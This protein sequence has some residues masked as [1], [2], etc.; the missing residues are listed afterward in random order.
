MDL[1]IMETVRRCHDRLA[2][3]RLARQRFKRFTYGRQWDDTM[4]TPDGSRVT[5]G[6]Y[7]GLNGRV[8][9][10]NNMIH[11]VVKTIIGH[12]RTSVAAEHPAPKAAAFNRLDELDARM[13]E[14][15]L[16]SG[17]AVQRVV[18]EHRPAGTGLWVDNVNPDDFFCSEI[19]DPRAIDAEV[20]GMFHSWSLTETVARFAG[21]S[22]AKAAEIRQLY[23][24]TDRC[25]VV[26]VWTLEAV[27]RL[28]CHDRMTAL[29]YYAPVER[30]R[31]IAAANRKRQ[32]RG[33]PGVSTRYEFC[34]GW[35]G[36][37]LTP[38]GRE[39]ASVTAD[40]HPFALKFYPLIDGEVHPFVEGLLDQQKYINRLITLIDNMMSTSA[41]GVLLFPE[42]SMSDTTTLEDIRH[43]W[44]SYDG[45]LPYNPRAGIPEPRQIV[46]NPTNCGAYELLNLE[47]KLFDQ[48]GGVGESLQGRLSAGVGNS[49]ALFDAQTKASMA[50][51]ADIFASFADFRL[52]R[53]RLLA[54][55][56]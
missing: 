23:A 8:P 17:C 13:L 54:D 34:A 37:W 50:S 44:A 40:R 47:M 55:G 24:D 35:R 32:R 20:M 18:S 2:P 52:C 15:Y 21:G 51:L 56:N 22:R 5:E 26:E 45:V 53:D 39:L 28:R 12:Y 9:L 48:A 4:L 16:V 30:E 1:D 25:R 19:R 36:R 27:E 33:K 43:L 41:K 49:A 10:T 38:D 7:A 29:Y 42:D 14:E 6:E 11:R 31:E 3:F 46:T